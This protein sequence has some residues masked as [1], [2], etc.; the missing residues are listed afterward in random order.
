MELLAFRDVAIEFSPEEWKCLDPAQQNLYRDVM[1]ENYRNLVSLGFAISNQTWS[2]VWSK[3]KSPT[4]YSFCIMSEILKRS[5]RELGTFDGCFW[6][7]VV[8]D[9]LRHMS[10]MPES[11]TVSSFLPIPSLH[12]QASPTPLT[13]AS[14]PKDYSGFLFHSSSAPFFTY[15]LKIIR[16]GLVT[17]MRRS[18]AQAFGSTEVSLLDAG[19]QVERRSS[20][21]GWAGSNYK[22]L[23]HGIHGRTAANFHLQMKK[24]KL[25]AKQQTGKI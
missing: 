1:L 19:L 5:E 15:Q 21:K 8:N 18:W 9:H 11:L 12:S 23:S 6:I 22:T 2:S 7:V 4:I 14:S 20:R 17:V 10:E 16:A 24:L 25:K 3:E 13:Q